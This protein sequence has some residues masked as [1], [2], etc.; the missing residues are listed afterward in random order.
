MNDSEFDYGSKRWRRFSREIQRRAGFRCERLGCERT[1]LELK[2]VGL[3]LVAH[4]LLEVHLFP[5]FAFN[6]KY[7]VSCCNQCHDDIHDGANHEFVTRLFVDGELFPEALAKAIAELRA[8]RQRIF[9]MGLWD[10]NKERRR[11]FLN[12][13]ETRIF[14]VGFDQESRL[15]EAN[16]IAEQRR[17][18]YREV[19]VL[20]DGYSKSGTIATDEELNGIG[21]AKTTNP[22]GRGSS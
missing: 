5:D 20:E 18:E 2:A 13:A 6:Q 10:V 14:M 17:Q 9:D 22:G 15:Q 12:A 4:H 8:W 11:R 16:E 1:E 19:G 21:I 7:C 3:Y